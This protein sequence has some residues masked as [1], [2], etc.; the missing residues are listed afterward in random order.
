[1]IISKNPV[2][3]IAEFVCLGDLVRHLF[4]CLQYRLESV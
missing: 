3:G 2:T 1:M 4:L